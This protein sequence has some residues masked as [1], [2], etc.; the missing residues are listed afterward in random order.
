MIEID[1]FEGLTK[2]SARVPAVVVQVFSGYCVVVM[3]HC[4]SFG[5]LTPA[6][7]LGL[8]PE[9]QGS[10]AQTLAARMCRNLSALE[11]LV[12]GE[13]VRFSVTIGA[14]ALDVTDRWASDMLR[15]AEQG[16]E[17]AIE[18]GRGIAVLALPHAPF[19]EA[20]AAADI[21]QSGAA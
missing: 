13:P 21:T 5:R 8:L 14:T 18:Q 1:D 17:D 12:D 15:R 2:R 6:R 10:G 3:R 16:L 7:F 4:D 19:A 20:E 11:V 9:T